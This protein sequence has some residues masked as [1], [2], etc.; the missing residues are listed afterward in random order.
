MKIVFTVAMH[1]EDGLWV[2]TS[3][4][5]FGEYCDPTAQSEA[6]LFSSMS[7]AK[8]YCE[9]YDVKLGPLPNRPGRIYLLQ[10]ITNDD[11]ETIEEVTCAE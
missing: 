9:R 5:L 10:E 8:A 11:T 6:L 1:D 2:M 7:A 3:P 4:G